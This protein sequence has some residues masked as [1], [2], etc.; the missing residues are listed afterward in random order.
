MAE[1]IKEKEEHKKNN[2][3]KLLWKEKRVL[4]ET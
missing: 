3:T 4:E 1:N 2:L